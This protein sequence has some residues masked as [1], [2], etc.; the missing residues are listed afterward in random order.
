MINK[1]KVILFIIATLFI[2]TGCT[3]N[4]APCSERCYGIGGEGCVPCEMDN[5]CKGVTTSSCDTCM[6]SHY[7]C[8]PK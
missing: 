7:K 1:T 2:I 5:K 4:S 3:K 8:V 6:D